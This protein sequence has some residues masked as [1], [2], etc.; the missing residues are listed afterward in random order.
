MRALGVEA[1]RVRR[2]QSVVKASSY[3]N[4]YFIFARGT[5]SKRKR[6]YASTCN[7]LFLVKKKKWNAALVVR[8]IFN[9]E[10]VK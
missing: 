1:R 10:A 7:M 5:L 6:F 4:T 3:S 9:I 2:L 8:I